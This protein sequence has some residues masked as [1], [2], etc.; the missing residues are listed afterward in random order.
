MQICWRRISP[1]LFVIMHWLRTMLQRSCQ[2]SSRHGVMN[3]GYTSLEHCITLLQTVLRSAWYSR[4]SNHCGSFH[5]HPRLLY[6][7]SH[8]ISA[9]PWILAI[10]LVNCSTD[11]RFDA[12]WMPGSLS[13]PTLHRETGKESCKGSMD[14]TQPS[15][16]ILWPK[17]QRE[18]AVGASSSH[19]GLWHTK[20]QCLP[21]SKRT[22][23]T[24]AYRPTTSL[25]W[26]GRRCR[27]RRATNMF[28]R[29]P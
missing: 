29:M 21:L 24:L 19:Q 15:G 18:T 26:G 5:F 1:T 10:H 9:H 11:D 25:L 3:E 28:C 7:N 23:I 8:A 13:L 27:S 14:E 20:Y 12:I 17:A 4:S 6:K 2:R 16:V 22:Y